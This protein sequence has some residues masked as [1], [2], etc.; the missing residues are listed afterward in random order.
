MDILDGVTNLLKLDRV[1]IYISYTVLTIFNFCIFNNMILD[2]LSIKHANIECQETNRQIAEDL[3]KINDLN[4]KISDIYNKRIL[5][6]IQFELEEKRLIEQYKNLI[7]MSSMEGNNNGMISEEMH[8]WINDVKNQI[9]EN[10]EN[11]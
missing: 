10:M 2:K 7:T 5:Q 4:A 8:N 3:L 9:K 1:M 6:K 11:K